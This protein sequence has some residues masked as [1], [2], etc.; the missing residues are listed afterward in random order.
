MHQ[1]TSPTL[2]A[3][4]VRRAMHKELSTAARVGYTLLLLVGFTGAG[5]VGSLWLTEPNP[6]PPQTH[7]TFGLLAIINLSWVVFAA[8]VLTQRKVLYAKQSVISG[9]MAVVF[10]IAFLLIGCAI[11]YERANTNGLI[12]I[13]VVATAQFI[14]AI[15]LLRR[16]KLR[17]N[18]LLARRDVLLKQLAGS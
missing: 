6:L 11:A 17:R 7:L 10:C 9:W 15:A 12:A 3:D 4:V 1:L 16:A 8:W 14:V 18:V 13:G 2:D 5:L